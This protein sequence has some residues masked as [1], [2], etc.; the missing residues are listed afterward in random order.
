MV[1]FLK[2]D[3]VKVKAKS[4]T[5]DTIGMTYEDIEVVINLINIFYRIFIIL[6][7]K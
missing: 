2:K 1:K 5:G 4:F 6:W 7:T 3:I